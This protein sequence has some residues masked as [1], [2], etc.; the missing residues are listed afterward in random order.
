MAVSFARKQVS[1]TPY[2]FQAQMGEGCR[3]I[4]PLT[5]RGPDQRIAAT[6]AFR[7]PLIYPRSPGRV[8]W[9]CE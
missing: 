4:A 8:G 6:I 3:T 9:F 7:K 2:V 1:R 5:S